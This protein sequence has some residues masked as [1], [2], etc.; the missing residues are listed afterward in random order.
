M[1]VMRRM[2]REGGTESDTARERIIGTATRLFASLGY[3]GTSAQMIADAAGLDVA[4]ITDLA[5]DKRDIYL[6]VMKSAY[7][8]KRAMYDSAFAEFTPDRAG[9]HR[10]VDHLLDFSVNHPEISE[11]WIH[12]W[13]GDA[14]DVTEMEAL[15]LKPILD[16]LT[17]ATRSVVGTDVDLRV[18]WWAVI[19]SVRGFVVGGMLDKEGRTVRP[20]DPVL[21]RQFRPHLHQLVDRV[22]KLDQ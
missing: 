19:W 1:R 22:L 21:L 8:A 16:R 18:A 20:S 14:A 3:D 11:L 6:A 5:G 4:T 15:Y 12:R 17:D 10:L 2:S 7:M 13:L 9:I